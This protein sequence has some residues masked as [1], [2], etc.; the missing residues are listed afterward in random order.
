MAT[1]SW[2]KEFRKVVLYFLVVV[3]LGAASG[4][5]LE[6]LAIAALLLVIYWL[7][8]LRRVSDWMRRPDVEPPEARGLWGEFFDSIYRL[9]RH[10]REERDR[11]QTAVSYLRDSLAALKDAAVLIDPSANIEWCNAAAQEL[12]G[13]QYPRDRGQAIV[14]LLR[15]PNFSAYFIEGDYHEPLLIESP[16]DPALQLQVE[17][18]AFGRGSRL[19]FCR[20]VTREQQLEKMRR[21][22]VANVS[23]ELRTPLTVISGYLLTL[24]DTDLGQEE[25]LQRPMLQMQQQAERME[26]LL[27]DLLWLS[28][29]EAS[30]GGEEHPAL[31]MR[32]LI[33]EVRE[34]ALGAYPDRVINTEIR[35]ECSINGNYK[36]LYSAVSNLVINAL[37]YSEGDINIEW[38]ERENACCLAVRDCGPGI[39]AVHLPRLTERFYRVDKSRS[40]GTGGTGLG[41]AIV[42]HVLAG[43]NAR[44]EIE[45]E[46]G[47]GS[48]FSCIFAL[49]HD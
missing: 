2:W 11:L 40:Q 46:V 28:Q 24:M 31:D 35:S 47:V 42:K 4:F 49:S 6:A 9:Q 17:V 20:D 41:L 23:H 32:D 38:S 16:L 7:N 15:V 37:K 3:G 45:S 14:N 29:I 43:H 25:R 34:F 36:H 21:D 10:D 22:F 13:L 18:T 19:M 48:T 12:L 27:R 5:G 33:N 39:D 44:L 1:A 26:T 30:E 8:Q